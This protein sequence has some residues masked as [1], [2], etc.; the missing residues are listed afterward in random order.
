M[1]ILEFMTGICIALKVTI[2]SLNLYK[3]A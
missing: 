2:K 1:L 3:P